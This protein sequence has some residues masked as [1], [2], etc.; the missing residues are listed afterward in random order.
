MKRIQEKIT[1]L[2]TIQNAITYLGQHMNCPIECL[3]FHQTPIQW[4]IR[5]NSRSLNFMVLWN[6]WALFRCVR[7]LFVLSKKSY[8]FKP[9]QWKYW[10]FTKNSQIVHTMK[11][12]IF[13]WIHKFLWK[14]SKIQAVGSLFPSA[15]NID[16]L[17]NLLDCS[18]NYSPHSPL[19]LVHIWIVPPPCLH[20]FQP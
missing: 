2:I 8:I 10:Y 20:T 9:G 4:L 16:P 17:F 12:P 6:T 19:H 11:C 15:P 5:G 13:T 1:P 14:S 3:L 18:Q 7:K